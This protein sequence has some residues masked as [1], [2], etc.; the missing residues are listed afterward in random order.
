V[1]RPRRGRAAPAGRP[2][3][4]LCGDASVHKKKTKK[5]CASAESNLR[6]NLSSGKIEWQQTTLRRTWQAEGERQIERRSDGSP[7][8][9]TA[10]ASLRL[11]D[12]LLAID[13]SMHAIS[14]ANVIVVR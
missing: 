4:R 9:P 14:A 10:A 8:S 12:R 2:R 13:F 5:A 7:S 6:G 11:L 1:R 3:T